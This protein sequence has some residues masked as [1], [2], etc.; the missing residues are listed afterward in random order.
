MDQ[1][2]TSSNF[3]RPILDDPKLESIAKGLEAQGWQ[4]A[5]HSLVLFRSILNECEFGK[6]LMGILIATS[7]SD[8]LNFE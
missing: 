3:P 1:N 6:C 7:D 5:Q 4:S 2:V 8:D